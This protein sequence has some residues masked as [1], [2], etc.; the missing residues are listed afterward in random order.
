MPYGFP[1]S[2]VHTLPAVPIG[3]TQPQV[4]SN[5]SKWNSSNPHTIHIS[6]LPTVGKSWM[7]IPIESQ[8]SNTKIQVIEDILSVVEWGGYLCSSNVLLFASFLM[9]HTAKIQIVEFWEV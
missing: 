2:Y 3:N 5:F 1:S 8:P 4:H 6:K 7:E 9:G